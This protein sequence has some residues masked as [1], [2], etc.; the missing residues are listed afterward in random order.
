MKILVTGGAG[1]IGSEITKE[2]LKQG[3]EVVV[4]DNLGTMNNLIFVEHNKNLTIHRIDCTTCE[5][6]ADDILECEH[7]FHLAANPDVRKSQSDPEIDFHNN[8]LATYKILKCVENSKVLKKFVFTSS[9]TVYGEPTIIPTPESYGPLLPISS[10]GATKLACEALISSFSTNGEFKSVIFRFA[11]VVG[12]TS[13]HGVIFD[14][15]NKLQKNSEQLEILGDGKQNKSYIYILDCISAMMKAT[16]KSTNATEIFNIGTDQQTTVDEIAN[17]IINEM[18]LKSVKLVH[19]D[20]LKNGRGWSGD[21]RSMLLDCNK[22]KKLGWRPRY[23]S[24]EAVQKTV[25]ELIKK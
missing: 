15:I 17:T 18:N 9:S 1:F 21:V 10:Y 2:F 11:N 20:S 23:S 5:Q 8:I 4:I 22:I 7:I 3:N 6:I 13:G 25:S 24:N 12:P 19:S 16:T 14:F